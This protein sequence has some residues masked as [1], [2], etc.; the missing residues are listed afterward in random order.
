[1]TAAVG[2]K[3]G[4]FALRCC[5]ASL[6]AFAMVWGLLTSS[7]FKA[8]HDVSRIATRL[9]AGDTYQA[10]VLQ[11]VL[12]MPEPDVLP[13]YLREKAILQLNLV[14]AEEKAKSAKPAD[15]EALEATVLTALS[16]QPSDAY[17]WLVLF[18]LRT[19]KSG[20]SI[21]SL[22][23]LRMSY[24]YGPNEGWVALPRSR[25]TMRL[26]SILPQDVQEKTV[27][28]FK[29]LVASGYAEQMADI[30]T[31]PGWPIHER[32]LASL[33]DVPNL[34]KEQFAEH[35]RSLNDALQVP[36]VTYT[37]YQR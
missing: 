37:P 36:G 23:A 4:K 26:F 34:P 12:D 25:F 10:T 35:L 27:Q 1:M 18:W 30:L 24:L 33:A 16:F 17:L 19:L 8:S 13:G 14:E 11:G 28:E 7:V 21:E 2:V 5:I 29:H 3:A 9:V 15:Y 22:S 31:G 20:I 32:L 6:A